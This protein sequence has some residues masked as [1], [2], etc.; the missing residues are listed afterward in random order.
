M[1]RLSGRASEFTGCKGFLCFSKGI[2]GTVCT[3]LQLGKRSVR[4]SQLGEREPRGMALSSA[5]KHQAVFDVSRTPAPVLGPLHSQV[6]P[7]ARRAHSFKNKCC[8]RPVF[9]DTRAV[10]PPSLAHGPSPHIP[11]HTGITLSTDWKADRHH[12]HN[13]G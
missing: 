5:A 4:L 8:H 3:L 13:C 10:T 11:W 6:Q 1:E 12:K 2:W 7:S 9:S